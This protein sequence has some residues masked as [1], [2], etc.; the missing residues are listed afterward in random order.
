MPLVEASK[1]GTGGDGA[2][3]TRA[4]V[5][6]PGRFRR[7][8]VDGEHGTRAHPRAVPRRVHDPALP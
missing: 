4:G 2:Q 6:V 3:L 7:I 1:G 8:E 5:D